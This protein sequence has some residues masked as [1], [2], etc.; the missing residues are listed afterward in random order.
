MWQCYRKGFYKATRDVDPDLPLGLFKMAEH[1]EQE[2]YEALCEEYGSHFVLN[3]IPVKREV[4][5]EYSPLSIVGQTDPVIIGYNLEPIRLY[6]VK[7][8][9]SYSTRHGDSGSA[10]NTHKHQS[11]FY[12]GELGIDE[13]LIPRPARSNLLEMPEPDFSI[14]PADIAELHQETID[15]FKALHAFVEEGDLPPPEPFG[16]KECE[17]CDFKHI[18]R[19]E[20]DGEDGWVK[21]KAGN[22]REVWREPGEPLKERDTVLGETDDN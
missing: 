5:T 1:A 12:A 6:E 7:S 13:V 21:I 17:W 22:G 18:C 16:D 20:D 8:S 4:P 15:Y 19:R 14:P 10:R 11:S 2:I 3:S 9:E